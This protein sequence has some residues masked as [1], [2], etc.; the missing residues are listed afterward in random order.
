MFMSA[1]SIGPGKI[2]LNSLEYHRAEV[3]FFLSLLFGATATDNVA[4]HKYGHLISRPEKNNRNGFWAV[5]Q[6]YCS[7]EFDDGPVSSEIVSPGI[8]LEK[9]KYVDVA[10]LM[11]S[12]NFNLYA[13]RTRTPRPNNGRHVIAKKS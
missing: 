2:N 5:L 13:D 6:F 9:R 10:N 1:Q 4:T 12:A 7:L 11:H 3:G 8:S